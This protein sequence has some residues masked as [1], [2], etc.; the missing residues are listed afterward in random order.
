[1][2]TTTDLSRAADRH[3][4]SG[5]GTGTSGIVTALA[6]LDPS[7]VLIRWA[8]HVPYFLLG[9]RLMLPQEL[10]LGSAVVISLFYAIFGHFIA[11]WIRGQGVARPAVISRAAMPALGAAALA[12]AMSV[13]GP[14][15]AVAMP[16][17]AASALFG[18]LQEQGFAIWQAY[19]GLM[20]PACLGFGAV[21][22]LT[23]RR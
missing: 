13:V 16:G 17:E 23:G 5:A 7:L 15:V 21:Q 9:S 11:M 14:A 8:G 3:E 12:L 2:Q 10:S 22:F 4:L 6:K 19:L 18:Q 20:L 1:M